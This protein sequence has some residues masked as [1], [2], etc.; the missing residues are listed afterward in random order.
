MFEGQ[1]TLREYHRGMTVLEL[2][3]LYDELVRLG[4]LLDEDTYGAV[5]AAV[6]P[7]DDKP[8]FRR[9]PLALAGC[10]DAWNAMQWA[11]LIGDHKNALKMAQ[12][13]GRDPHNRLVPRISSTL[14]ANIDD[15][16]DPDP[17]RVRRDIDP[18][19]VRRPRSH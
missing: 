6:C 3:E 13:L 15:I 12:R 16:I 10:E 4:S 19:R 17:P 1:I 9:C 18:P 8:T 11:S 7:W 2:Q 14:P 5:L